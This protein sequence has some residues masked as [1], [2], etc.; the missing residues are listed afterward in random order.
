LAD[1]SE[2]ASS[3]EIKK[4]T[5]QNISGIELFTLSL[6]T[7]NI[8]IKIKMS[9]IKTWVDDLNSMILQGKAMEAFEKYYADD[10]EMQENNFPPTVGK[11]ANRQREIEFFAGITAFR[12]AHIHDVAFGP[13][14]SMVVSSMDYSHKEY[15]ERKYTQ[16]AVQHWK[17]GKI[18][19]ERFFYG[20]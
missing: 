8:S 13:D 5:H 7:L 10:V 17:D 11:D 1:D 14:V 19:K 20:S 12:G 18:V 4:I 16:V 2:N 6:T 15:G 9:D 3:T